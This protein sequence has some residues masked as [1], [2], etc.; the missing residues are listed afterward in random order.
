M[1][2]AGPKNRTGDKGENG[3][4]GSTPAFAIGDV[5]FGSKPEVTMTGTK[6]NP[7]LNFVLPRGPKGKAGK[8]GED[9]KNGRSMIYSDLGVY[10]ECEPII[11]AIIFG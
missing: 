2:N 8:D 4:D 5:D 3:I 6:D 11:N 7:V 9:G 10:D 1:A